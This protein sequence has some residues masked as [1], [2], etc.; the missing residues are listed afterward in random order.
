MTVPILY[1]VPLSQP[2]RAVMWLMLYKRLPFEMVLINP[3]SKGEKGSRNPLFLAKNPA[4][5]IPCYE[6]L[7]T[8]IVLGEAHAIMCYLASKHGWNDVYPD[9]LQQRARVDWYLHFHHRNIRDASTGLMAPHFR[10]DLNIPE[11]IQRTSLATLERGLESLETGWLA[12]SRFLVGDQLTIADMAAYVEIGQ[13]QPQFA[14]V[15]NFEAYPN[16]RHWLNDMT[17]ID[18]HDDVHAVL[19]DIGDMSM[20]E[21]SL[22][23]IVN[24]NKHALAVLKECL[25]NL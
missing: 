14:N 15:F 1:G 5:T 18:R 2:V 8:G 12:Q 16:V 11:V 25:T 24:A 9:D 17:K 22:E 13:L 4:G 19:K 21:P 23:K 3:G 7:D 10:K 6:E 20:E